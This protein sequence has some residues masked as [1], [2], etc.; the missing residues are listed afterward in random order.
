MFQMSTRQIQSKLQS[1]TPIIHTGHAVQFYETDSSLVE[2]VVLHVS[3]ALECGD[4]AIVVATPAHCAAFKNELR[5]RGIDVDTAIKRGHYIELDAAET[6]DKLLVDGWPNEQRFEEIIGGLISG[7]GAMVG[8]GHRVVVYG[9]MVALLWD[10][11]KQDATVHLEKL[12]NELSGKHSFFLLCGYPIGAF[13]RLEHRRAFFNICGE[14]SH[15][16]PAE[17]YP[18]DGNESRRRRKVA[19]L[20]QKAHA[21]E[22]EIRLSQQRILLLQDATKA[23]TW[24]LDLMDDT[25]SF[26]STAA[27]LLGIQNNRAT[28]AQ[29]MDLMY[30]SGDR[31]VMDA[32]LQQAR[33]GRREFVAS[34]RIRRGDETRILEIRGKTLYNGGYPLVLGVLSDV[35][36]LEKRVA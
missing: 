20:Q 12:W 11:G 4:V 7:A 25:V 2:A 28:I 19:Q 34:F 5:A 24:E 35:T 33:K 8:H 3:S 18:S 6:L 14:H 9:E 13:D 30:Y 22:N 15:V 32:G 10:Q 29:F 26:S 17:S 21:L 16:N 27:K 36:P 1:Q 23:G 31:D